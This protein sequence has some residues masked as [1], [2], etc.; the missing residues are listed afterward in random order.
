MATDLE[1]FKERAKMMWS[2]GNYA[3]VAP[4]LEGAAIRLVGAADI[5]PGHEVLDVAA[6]TG[7]AAVAAARKGA[8]VR[9]SDLTP[10]LVEQ[11]R[12][13]TSAEG[14]DVD[15]RE[16]DAEDLPFED[17]TFDRVTSSF[18][19]I[20][21]PRPEVATREMFRVTK[22]GGKVAVTS[23]ADRGRGRDFF[24]LLSA[25]MP[26]PPPGL[27]TARDWGDE[28]AL[29]RW[30]EPHA[31]S[32]ELSSESV[33]WTFPSGDAWL[34]FLERNANVIVLAKSLLTKERYAELR[35]DLQEFARQVERPDGSVAWEQEYLIAVGEKQ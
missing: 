30:F 9:A 29:Q 33:P 26:P 3:A 27:A 8:K 22:S 25:Y 10:S 31:S 20:F 13:R 2:M 32:I 21:A 23:W 35:R 16:A 15:W 6:G 17:A 4:I 19:V 7:N 12:A 24:E 34:D 28:A 5:G 11:G 1:Q 14:L 18:G